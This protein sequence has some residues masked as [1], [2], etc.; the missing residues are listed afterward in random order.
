M[1]CPPQFFSVDSEA[2][3]AS[4]DWIE[5][6][7]DT[8]NQKQRSGQVLRNAAGLHVK[9]ALDAE[10]RGRLVSEEQVHSSN[11]RF[12]QREQIVLREMVHTEERIL[13][14]EYESY[15][16]EF[17]QRYFED[18]PEANRQAMRREKLDQLRDQGRLARLAPDTRGTEVD[19]MILLDLAMKWAPVFEKWRLRRAVQ[20][21]TLPF[22]VAGDAFIQTF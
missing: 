16:R 7:V 14:A 2:C 5:I 10:A 4:L 6:A 20:Q 19:D 22:Q 12:R 3:S 13:I 9:I 1:R 11:R 18:L 17:A 15:R 21:A 8:C